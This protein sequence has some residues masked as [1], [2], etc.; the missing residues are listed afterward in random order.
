[1]Q[2]QAFNIFQSFLVSTEE[3]DN[4]ASYMILLG[5]P[6]TR[7]SFVVKCLQ[8]Y[9]SNRNASSQRVI[10]TCSNFGLPAVLIGGQ[11]IYSL[12]QLSSDMIKESELETRSLSDTELVAKNHF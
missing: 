2:Q 7:K 1:M 12:F 10:V 3:N 8:E 4:E 11:T 9:Q 5:G 6:G